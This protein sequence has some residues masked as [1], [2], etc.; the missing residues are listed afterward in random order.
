MEYLDKP[1]HDET[2]QAHPAYWRGKSRGINDVLKIVSD[3]MLNYDNG[4]GSNNNPNIE[5]MR[6]AL[7]QWRELVNSTFTSDEAKKE[8]EKAK[9]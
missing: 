1:L 2:S 5:A 7:I 3:I 6:R 4:S 8:V 9:K